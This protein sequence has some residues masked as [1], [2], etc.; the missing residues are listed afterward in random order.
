MLSLFLKGV[1]YGAYPFDGNNNL[2]LNLV[3]AGTNEIVTLTATGAAGVDGG[4]F[5]VAWSTPDGGTC[6]SAPI[7]FDATT[8]VIKSTIEAMPNFR[9]VV[10]A[11]GSVVTAVTLTFS[12]HYGNRPLFASAHQLQCLGN[13]LAATAVLQGIQ[14]TVTT[15]GLFG[16]TTG[17]KILDLHA[18]PT[19][20]V[21]LKAGGKN[22]QVAHT[23]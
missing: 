21:T 15:P 22:M 12:G 13:T 14:A 9:G 1:K 4:S 18:Y 7:A 17:T 6:Y 16:M 3:A 11:G 23:M 10:T 5:V 20:F 19:A 2:S 8:A